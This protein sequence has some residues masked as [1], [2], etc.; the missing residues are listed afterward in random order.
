MVVLSSCK[1]DDCNDPVPS[2]TYDSF[3]FV[4]DSAT[5]IHSFIDCDGDIGLSSTDTVPPY[6]YGGD[7]YNNLKVELLIWED[8]KWVAAELDGEGFDNRI[9]PIREQTQ[10]ETI[11]G[12]IKYNMLLQAL[13][14]SDSIRFRSVL[15]D[16]ALNESTPAT[17]STIVLPS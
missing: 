10:E 6:N 14:Y 4:G 12:K 17:S 9:P 1:K 16:R 8:G 3:E 5:L 15:I 7:Y 2:L 13:R 11:E